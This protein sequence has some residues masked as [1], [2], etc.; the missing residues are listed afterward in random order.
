M[1]K[2]FTVSMLSITVAASSL[3][4]VSCASSHA[5]SVE[6]ITF[7][8]LHLQAS[9]LVYIAEDQKFFSDCGLAVTLKEFDTGSATTNAVLNG[10]ADMATLS[11]FVM[12]GNV[13]QNDSMSI[14]GVMD[15]TM[16]IQIVAL[17]SRGISKPADLAGKKIGFGQGSSS[18]FYL[19]RYLELNGLS[20][21]SVTAVNLAPAKLEGALAAGDVDAIVGWAPYTLQIVQHFVNDTIVWNAQSSQ[22]VYGLITGNTAWVKTHQEAVTRFWKALAK[23]QDYLNRHPA[24]SKAIIVKK[25]NYDPAYLETIWPSLTFSLSLDQS[26]ITAMEDESRWMIQNGLTKVTA[27]PDFLKVISEDALKSVKPDVVRIIR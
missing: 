14:L 23:A 15:K 20:M 10:D 26:L 19:G 17:K 24:E 8:N 25:L 7:A 1:K 4:G 12:V 18:E 5:D 11:E 22:P 9:T 13:M 16:T 3:L 6:S 2:R 21:K 27:V